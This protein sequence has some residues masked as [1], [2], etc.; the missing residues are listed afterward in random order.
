MSSADKDPEQL[1]LSNVSGGDA[2]EYTHSVYNHPK[3]ETIQ[4]F[5]NWWVDKFVVQ[6][7]NGILLVNKKEQTADTHKN[8]AE[9]QR[10]YAE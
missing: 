9:S 4:M 10:H 7:Y 2:K 5:F 3:L 1:E 6:P 8:L